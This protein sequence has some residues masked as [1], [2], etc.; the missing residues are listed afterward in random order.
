[1]PTQP[2]PFVNA[3]QS[4][5]DELAG[6]S[7]Q[8]INVTIDG[9]GAVRRRPGIAPYFTGIE[10]SVPGELGLVAPTGL[11]VSEANGVFAVVPTQAYLQSYFHVAP[12]GIVPIGTRVGSLRP[13]FAETEMLLVVAAGSSM[14]KIV[15][16]DPA[17]V[18]PLGGDPPQASHVLHNSLELHANDMVDFRN[19][20]R[21]SAPGSG[22]QSYAAHETWS[23]ANLSGAGF[24]FAEA[25]P[26]PIVA[27]YENTNEIWCFGT[28]SLQLFAG[29]QNEDRFAV[30][31]TLE[32]GCSAPYSVIK[33]ESEFYWLDHMRRL[34]K[35]SG[36]GTEPL[37]TPLQRVIQGLGRVDDC[38]GY[39]VLQGPLDALVWTFPTAGRTFVLQ[40]GAGWA[41]WTRWNNGAG[42]HAPFGV[43]S[44]AYDRS[45]GQNLVGAPELGVGV[46]Q[47]GRATDAAL[48]EEDEAPIVASVTTGFLNRGTDERKWCKAIRL[49]FRP[50]EQREPAVR[51]YLEYRDSLGPWEPPIPIVVDG[52][53]PVCVLSSLGVYRRRQWRYTFSDVA[54]ELV[55]SGAEE[56]FDVLD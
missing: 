8:A 14:S 9:A 23:I 35:S 7:P 33:R 22:T 30:V 18:V 34:V 4:G 54:D 17:S 29:T 43:T 49:T 56:T 52:M 10:A 26:D 51:G 3:L 15:L 41:E 47:A 20:I 13:V 11:H 6:A 32:A 25:S 5:D 1:M 16:S 46:L 40:E 28:R 55:F 36:R 48:T 45:T 38:Y 44:H 31:A 53:D 39:R 42:T 24:F 50:S 2:V 27:L 37:S 12:G 19:M 21:F